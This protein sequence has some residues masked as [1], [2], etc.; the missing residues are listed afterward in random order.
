M[1]RRVVM[2]GLGLVTPLGTGVEKT[3][4]GLCAGRSGIGAISRF[5][6]SGFDSRIAGEVRDFAAEDW[7]DKKEARRLD[8]FVQYGLA[9]ATMAV[10]ESGLQ[11]SENPERMG[12]VVGSGIG[13]IGAME[14]AHQKLTEKGPGRVSPFFVPQTLI[15]LVAGNISIRFGLLGPSWSPVSAC[16]TGAHAVGEAMRL[17]QR[18]ECD[19]VVAGGCE[20]PIT[21]L[22]VAGFSAMKA[23]CAD[24]NDTPQQASR[25]FDR[26]RSGFVLAEGAGIVVLEELEH[27]RRRGAPVL[28]EIAGYACNCDAHHI[29]APAPEG[30]GASRCMRLAL[31]DARI[32]AEEVGYLNA[33]GTSTPFNDASETQ[34]VKK[35]F[36][37]HARKMAISSTKSMLG[38]QLGAAGSVEAVV[39]ALALHRGVLPPTVNYETPDPE[40]DLDYVPN[41]ARE[42]KVE[43]AISNSFGFGGTNAVL[44][45]RRFA[46]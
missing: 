12:C 38:H 4:Q 14:E 16:A 40:C 15:N 35:V 2:T 42:A 17:I 21:P 24:R 33:H 39:C 28:A 37:E 10:K 8:L 41:Q 45:L 36:G 1:S 6:T 23:M 3:W 13:G 29:T 20:A 11:V 9:A 26:D 43:V 32:A 5:D 34:A 31:Q 18:G 27:A 7:L 44:V 30:A 19:A 25:P 46:G 22:T